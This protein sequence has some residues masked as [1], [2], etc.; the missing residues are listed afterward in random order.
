M[1]YLNKYF[2]FINVFVMTIYRLK[3]GPAEFSSSLPQ[4]TCLEVSSL[5]NK[6]WF[7]CV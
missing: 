3:L 5:P 4:H 2:D 1:A 7:T 6:S